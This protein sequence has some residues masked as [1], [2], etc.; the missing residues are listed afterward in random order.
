MMSIGSIMV[1]ARS[2]CPTTRTSGGTELHDKIP[3]SWW[4]RLA[5]LTLKAC[6]DMTRVLRPQCTTP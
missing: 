6:G 1:V 2:R 5:D 4:P 3:I